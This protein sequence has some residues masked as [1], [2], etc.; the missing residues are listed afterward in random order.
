MIAR[1]RGCKEGCALAH[2][3]RR[4]VL[5]H[6]RAVVCTRT[7]FTHALALFAPY[8]LDKICRHH[9]LHLFAHTQVRARSQADASETARGTR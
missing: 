6:A 2:G 3:H 8:V 9:W 5:A 1:E 4:R 7:R